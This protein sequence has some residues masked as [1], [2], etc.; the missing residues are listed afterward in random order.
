M[1]TIKIKTFKSSELNS[2]FN[3]INTVEIDNAPFDSGAFGEVYFCNSINNKI[4][5]APQVLKIFIDDSTGSSERGIKTIYKLQ[6]KI[7]SHNFDLKQKQ[8]IPIEN[9]NALKALPQFSFDGELNGKRV[10]GYSANL[11]KKG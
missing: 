1:K 9:I 7:I 6:D 11:L 4:I 10:V 5:S 8:E 2:E 3:V